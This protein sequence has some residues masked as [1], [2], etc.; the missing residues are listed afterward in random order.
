MISQLSFSYMV[1]MKTLSTLAIILL[2]MMMLLPGT[3][4]SIV[5][6]SKES[7][8]KSAT[9]LSEEFEVG[10]GKVV[11]KTLLDIN[12]PKGH[13]GVKSFD[14]EVVDEDGKSVPLY[15]TY[16]HH[17]FAVKY[18]ENITMSDYIKQSHDLRNGIEFER[19]DGMCQG[20]LLPHYWGLGG[21]SRGTSS[22]LPD[23]F[24]VELGN[25][26]KLKDGFKEKWLFSI[27]VIDTRGTHD[28][29]GCSECR[30]KLLNLPNNF[31]NVT[32]GINGQLLP[33][34]YKGGL[35]CCQDNLQCKLRN[36]FHGPT[37]KLSLRYKIRWVDWDEHQVPLRFYILDSTDRVIS[38][39]STLIHD[40][41]AEYTIPRN[42]DSDSPHVKKANIPM[43]KGGYLIYGTAHM[44]TGVVNTTLYGQIKDGEIL[45]LE[46][47]YENKFRTGAM[48]HFYIYLADEI[49]NKDLKI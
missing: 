5:V 12:F 32:M 49:P 44:H 6:E 48:G 18:I 31:Y 16:L 21:E 30:C 29:K 45:T 8:I 7:Y 35:F 33:R 34:N 25:P 37:R 20:F 1:N 41:Q 10:P 11:V 40:C 46:S 36:D 26:T 38:N 9:F 28:R 42:H 2:S 3:T 4:Q 27:M 15:E 43:T 47:I 39:G 19:N 14:V 24:A 17:W 23:P 13:I 22:N